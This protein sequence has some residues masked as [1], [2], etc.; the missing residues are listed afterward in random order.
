[1]S[2]VLI[3]AAHPDDENIAFGAT[4]RNFV[5]QGR[6]FELSS[7]TDIEGARNETSINRNFL[8]EKTAKTL[9]M[10]N[11]KVGNFLYN[12]LDG[13]LSLGVVKFIEERIH[14]DVKIF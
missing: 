5:D 3:I 1:M 7:L 11:Y 4:I 14:H 9:R 2:R 10:S 12:A 6:Q 13:I 8:L